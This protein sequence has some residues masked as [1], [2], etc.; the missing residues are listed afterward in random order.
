M[1]HHFGREHSHEDVEDMEV[2]PRPSMDEESDADDLRVPGRGAGEKMS[3][4]EETMFDFA[5]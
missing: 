2:V 1:H 4:V 3:G 5:S